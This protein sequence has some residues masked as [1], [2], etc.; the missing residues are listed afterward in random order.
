MDAYG[1]LA[2]NYAGVVTFASS[3]PSAILPADY[4]YTVGNN[5]DNGTHNFGVV[6]FTAGDQTLIVTDKASGVSGSVMITVT[7]PGDPPGGHADASPS[8]GGNLQVA[9]LDW[10]F[11]SLNDNYGGVK[12]RKA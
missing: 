4:G 5:K 11:A 8:P 1:N 10:F 9:S 3:D 7:S 12:A 2:T 6:F